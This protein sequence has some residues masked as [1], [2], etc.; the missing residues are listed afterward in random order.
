MHRAI[1]R[2]VVRCTSF[3]ILISLVREVGV[4][5]GPPLVFCDMANIPM[6]EDVQDLQSMVVWYIFAK[7]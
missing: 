4:Q 6:E 1:S 2:V 7:F 3:L 5:V